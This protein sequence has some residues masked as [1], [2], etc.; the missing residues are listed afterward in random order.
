MRQFPVLANTPTHTPAY[1]YLVR[2][3]DVACC[4]RHGREHLDEDV[5]ADGL[6]RLVDHVF[7]E[8]DSQGGGH[9]RAD[10]IKRYRQS[11]RSSRVADGTGSGAIKS[12]YRTYMLGFTTAVAAGSCA[13]AGSRQGCQTLESRYK[14]SRCLVDP[15]GLLGRPPTPLGGTTRLQPPRRKSSFLGH[16]SHE[17]RRRSEY[18]Y[19]NGNQEQRVRQAIER[20]LA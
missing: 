20:V 12:R 1:A 11:E 17:S 18:L 10:E 3:D 14:R 19:Y 9:R 13:M 4:S 15:M 5:V 8:R 2:E 7:L 16:E 6:K